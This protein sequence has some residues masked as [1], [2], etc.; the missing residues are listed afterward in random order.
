MCTKHRFQ[1]HP[2]LSLR[3]APGGLHTP[4]PISI[5]LSII[6]FVRL[7]EKQLLGVLFQAIY[8]QVGELRNELM[9]TALRYLATR[10]GRI[11]MT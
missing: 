3:L 6:S 8:R 7:Q 1:Y 9:G 5:P 10:S 2:P 4:R 11:N